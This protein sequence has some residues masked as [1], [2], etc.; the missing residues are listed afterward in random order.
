[1]S[2]EEKDKK[3]Q[4]NESTKKAL[5]TGAKAAAN[6]YAGP[7]GGKAV[8]IA[9][10]TKLGDDVLNKG[11]ETLNRNRMI[12]NATQ[13]ADKS[14]LLDSADKAID[15]ANANKATD[16]LK[17][18]GSEVPDKTASTGTSKKKSSFGSFFSANKNSDNESDEQDNADEG[19]S[20]SSKIFTFM[21]K[22]PI[23]FA[24][25]GGGFLL[26]IMILVVVFSIVSSAV[27]A[28]SDFFSGIAND[29]MGLFT[30]DQRELE[31]E[32]Y[33]TLKDVQRELNQKYNVCID[34]NL[35][36]AALTINIS[37]DDFLEESNI[38]DPS[39]D[40]DTI[41]NTDGTTEVVPYKRMKKQI[42][43][44]ANMQLMS[45]KYG[46]DKAHK[47]ATGS[48]CSAN[49]GSVLVDSTTASNYDGDLF[50]NGAD[51]SSYELIASHD[52]NAF[53]SFFTKKENEERNYAYYLYYPPFSSDGS[54]DT[55]SI[56]TDSRE[57]SIGSLSTKEDS[58]F[59]WNLVNS[60]ISDYYDDY[61][62]SKDKEA[63]RVEAIKKIADEIYLLYDEIG[64]NQTCAVV[65]S[66]PS[67]LCP[68]GIT[69]GDIGTIDFEEYIAGVVSNEAYTSEGME[70]LKAQAVA[71]RT[72]AL[73][74]T[75][76]CKSS[77]ANSTNAQTFTRN[78]NDN[79]K[80]AVS[81]TAGEILVDT[82]GSIFSS[83]YDSFCYD[84]KDCPDSVKN[85]DGSYTVTYTKV[86]NGEKH[87]ITLSDSSQY[88]RITHGQ[89]HA[90]G[91]SQLLSYQ[92]AKEGYSYK[93]ILSYFYS[94]G[95]EIS[96][97][98]SPASTEKGIIVQGP[99]T[100]Y[101]SSANSSINDFNQYIYSQ[102]RKTGVSTRSG[103][104]AAGVSLIN[105]FYTKTGYLLPYELYPSGKYSGYGIDSSW[106]TNTGR[107]DYPLNGLDCSGFIS[108]AIHNGGYTYDVRSAKG[109]GDAGIK[110]PWNKGTFDSSAQ[111]GDLI[112]N[113]PASSNGTTGHIRMIVDIT[114]E[115]YVVAEASGRKNGV[116]V[117]NISFTST[118]SYYLVDMSNYYANATAVTD[119]PG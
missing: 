60:F 83:Q 14:G 49:S 4:E 57:L 39:G 6:A 101:L 109:W 45:K 22:H 51:S 28:V 43:L 100:Q 56:P 85:S 63:E 114:S 26:I 15:V 16:G 25:V 11:A 80:I 106:G 71:A 75:D 17:K 38:I 113:A 58:V 65:Y 117:T 116:R 102:V 115:G 9:S 40:G 64:P 70:A 54:C 42:K 30:D 88:G 68:N 104:V 20:Y 23:I 2:D 86:P 82:N 67:S 47:S 29:F 5:K 3:I 107:S 78:I 21:A 46:L 48:Y 1:M 84:D 59:Y 105:G 8:D 31:Q 62:P 53:S 98:L 74:A 66:G 110:R 92:M 94:D 34:V 69:V 13:A 33:D 55:S 111:P 19:E 50:E 90:H 95:V 119:Y 61:L 87:T 12:S 79:A 10:K 81:S 35:I 76:Y 103:V 93:E 97:V 44:L 52:L 96:L 108:W 24:A 32:Y 27:G 118:G 36:T 41:T 73:K 89:G 18:T 77:I 99:I 112:Y 91:M 72:Y 37:P 7:V